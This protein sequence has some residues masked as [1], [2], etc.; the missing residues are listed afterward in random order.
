MLPQ[1]I[2]KPLF[3]QGL[4]CIGIYFEINYGINGALR[5]TKIIKFSSSHKCWYI[6]L[7][8]EN[9]NKLFFALKG[10]AEIEQSALHEYLA[11]K[12]KKPRTN[13]P[14]APAK[15]EITAKPSLSFV[16]K[17]VPVNSGYVKKQVTLYKSGKI[18]TVNAHII[19]AMEQH[20]KLKAYSS[21]TIK[22]YLGEMTQLLSLLHTIPADDLTPE[23]LKRYLVHC[24]DKLKLTENTLHSRINA[25]KFYYE[26]VLGREKF[27]W[28][29]PR[30]K[31]QY[32]LPKVLGESELKRLFNA[33]Q[34]KK[35]KAI[36][37]TAYSAGLRVSEVVNLELKHIDRSRMQLLIKNAKGKKD[38]YVMLSPVLLDILSNYYKTSK[39][40]PVTYIFEGPE[41]GTP[42]SSKSMQKIFQM[43]REKAGI[44][45]DLTFH[46]LRHS[47][48]TH[49]LEKGV[50][51]KYI[52]DLLGHFDIKTTA[53]YLHVKREHLVNIVSPLDDLFSREEII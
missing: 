14:L 16:K 30:P 11:E 15:K 27:F 45:K 47:F 37:F 6:P 5:K 40:R 52:R 35:H 51:I 29:I 38:R 2:L 28:E 50:D 39:P 21:S 41:P 25:M 34:N 53:R 44:H 23:H 4:E 49:L 8:K 9:Y 12:K 1:V 13:E 20:L 19:P 42:Y 36:L 10:K 26:Q 31:K 32:I 3:H 7:S 43:A 22:T 17:S 18:Q 48:A 46:S 33:L 24:Y